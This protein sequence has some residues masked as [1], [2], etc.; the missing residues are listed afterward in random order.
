MSQA[1]VLA[2]RDHVEGEVVELKNYDRARR[3]FSSKRNKVCF[4]LRSRSSAACVGVPCTM[5]RRTS[6]S[7]W[8]IRC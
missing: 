1:A 3:S 6:T 5:V 2:A 8:A 7:C 4:S